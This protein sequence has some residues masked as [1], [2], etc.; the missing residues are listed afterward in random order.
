VSLH[1]EGDT[2]EGKTNG[3]E[4]EMGERDQGGV[5]LGGEGGAIWGHNVHIQ[6]QRMISS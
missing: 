2:W 3:G 1:F 5:K 4:R 6:S